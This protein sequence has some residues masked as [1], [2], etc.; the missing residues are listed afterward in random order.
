MS[1]PQHDDHH[2]PTVLNY[3]VIF[4]ALSIFT[5]VSFV[6]NT[7]QR[8]EVIS[9]EI[10]FIVILVVAIIKAAL[11]GA[12]FM[13]LKF[14]WNRVGFMIIPAFIL[15]IMMMF[16]LLPDIVLAWR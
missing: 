11:V 1:A 8:Q 10:S 14:D 2:G 15:A 7:M 16:V 6:V 13:H 12:Y 3:M 9:A 5:I 4:A